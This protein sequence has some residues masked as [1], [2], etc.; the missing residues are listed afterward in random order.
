MRSFAAAARRAEADGVSWLTPLRSAPLHSAGVRLRRP[1]PDR[2]P[3]HARH[4]QDAHCLHRLAIGTHTGTHI[5]APFHFV[6]GG[7]FVAAL[8]LAV[9]VGAPLFVNL[10]PDGLQLRESIS[11]A[12]LAPFADRGRAIPRSGN[13][14]G[15]GGARIV[16][17][18]TGWTAKHYGTPA[19]FVH[20]YLLPP[21]GCGCA[22]CARRVARGHGHAVPGQDACG[23]RRGRACVHTDSDRI[24]FHPL[25]TVFP[26]KRST[27]G[28][29]VP[30]KRFRT[31]LINNQEMSVGP[32][33]SP[34]QRL[35][36]DVLWHI[37][38]INADIF[39]D[40]T[41]LETTLATSYVCHDWRSL[42][43]HSTSIWAHVINLSHWM[44]NTVE[45]SRELIRRSGTA[46][47]WIK[48]THPA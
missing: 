18:N 37:F 6:P 23:R 20:P 4:G 36:I 21:R 38:N 10:S 22:A 48:N 19:Y 45:G 15:G 40:D 28:Q 35:D 31:I 12:R 29:F 5:D 39:D 16:L 46:L 42:L 34:I 44:W 27:I 26:L 8:P 11:C 1:R 25:V 24:S 43:L 9:Y 47:P 17:I 32:M 14:G 33:T 13:V 2:C 3:A 41:A 7:R 30:H